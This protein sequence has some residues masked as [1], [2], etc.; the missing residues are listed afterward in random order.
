M[1]T[2][3][4]N[5][6]AARV[7]G[8]K[9]VARS[10]VTGRYFDGTSFDQIESNALELRP[11]TT[12][13]DFRLVWGGGVE[14]VEIIT[15][16]KVGEWDRSLAATT[17]KPDYYAKA[18]EFVTAAHKRDGEKRSFLVRMQDGKEY[19][20]RV[21]VDS[22]RSGGCAWVNWKGDKIALALIGGELRGDR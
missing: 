7:A 17:I 22:W 19:S 3:Q 16:P 13:E 20:R 5:D 4:T 9:L 11:G 14:V 8:R 12:A 21:T 2:T 18:R 6:N 10:T 15:V 1:T